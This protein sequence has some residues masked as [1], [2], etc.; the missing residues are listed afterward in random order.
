MP[1][2]LIFN[3]ERCLA[4]RSCE[5]ACAVVH[6]RTRRLD[7]AIAEHPLPRR[8]VS[9]V[10]SEGGLEALRCE[11][12][13]E[14]L[15]LFS[16]K[17]GALHR[18]AEDGRV[19]LDEER[20]LGCLMCLMVCPYGIRP[21]VARDRVTR[22]D[23]CGDLATPACVEA[24]PT[25]A[26][27]AEDRPSQGVQS[28]YAGHVLVVGS[29][30]AGIAACE[31]AREHA[32]GCAITVV[33]ADDQPEYSRPLLAYALAGRLPSSELRW[34]PADYLERQIGAT[35]LRGVRA[36]SLDPT[37]RLLTLEDGREIAYDRLIVATGARAT[38]VEI[39]G[40]G[41]PGVHGL[42]N[43]DDLDGLAELAQPERHG[44]V[45]GGG[46]VGLQ[47]CEALIERG[48]KVTLVVRSPYVLSQTVDEAVGRRVGELFARHG[49][50]LRTGRDVTE[51]LGKTRV[52]G[53]RLDTGEQL[54][55]DV[56]VV[57]KGIEPAIGWVRESGLDTRRG[58][59]VDMSGQTSVPG[60]FAAGDCAEVL[61]PVSGRSTVSG[62]WPVAY[63]MGR[64]AGCT[65]VGVERTAH[66]ALRMNAS[67][68]FG[69]S[70][71]SI[72]EV[73]LAKLP[74]ATEHVLVDRAD[75][76]RKLVDRDGRL[77]GALLYGDVSGAGT[78]YRLYREQVD[79]GT[80]TPEELAGTQLD[81]V[82]DL[83]RATAHAA[84][85]T[86]SE[87]TA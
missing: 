25:H 47:V 1:S 28:G 17:S 19:T 48:M 63:E 3:R 50:A 16:C 82:L 6:S 55:A 13:D 45:L 71:M 31:A 22:C 75:A 44:V 85:A 30:A 12:C 20:C 66:G 21:D 43:L 76:Y 36:R 18:R 70:I 4:C 32:P 26:L 41:L 15:C 77:V 38:T 74:G 78:Y 86:S 51:I 52:E 81:L 58:I 65:A 69:V 35:V 5:L 7:G 64:A 24:C 39:P 42:R 61:D 56:V 84:G 83:V 53:V 37:R 33:T 80:V 60:V 40:A 67:R 2:T 27:L 87:A 10:R 46:N 23:V 57:G 54:P 34:R 59:V 9:I 29:S 49:V 8:R 11:Q 62:I 73:L 79:L 72:G 14:P 68:F